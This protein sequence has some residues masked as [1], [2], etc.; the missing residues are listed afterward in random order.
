MSK[1]IIADDQALS[2]EGLRSMLT[3]INGCEVLACVKDADQLYEALKISDPDLLIISPSLP[4]LGGISAIEK[5][6]RFSVLVL[7]NQNFHT[8]VSDAI[9]AGAKGYLLKSTEIEEIEFAIRSILQGLVYITPLAANLLL[10]QE[11]ELQSLTSREI[12][13]LKLLAAGIPNRDVAKRLHISSRTIDSHR[14]NIMKKLSVKSNSE[15]VQIAIRAGL[16]DNNS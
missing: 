15:L 10:N 16:I 12:E 3:R 4:N 6:K 7:S 11:N 5:I 13:V 1:I 14:S 2:R 9:K 8:P